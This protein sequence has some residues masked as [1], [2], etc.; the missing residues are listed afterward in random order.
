[1]A[2]N[3]LKNG[4]NVIVFD[5]NK[6]SVDHLKGFGASSAES[7]AE[8]ASQAKTL[9]TMLPSS[10]HVQK[11]SNLL[12]ARPHSHYPPRSFQDI[13]ACCPNPIQP[14]AMEYVESFTP[15]TKPNPK[16]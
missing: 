4:K 3:L 9:I 2:T 5:L 10:P 14:E 1:M 11:V 8:V 16:P 12:P 6:G 13:K 7:P 15:G